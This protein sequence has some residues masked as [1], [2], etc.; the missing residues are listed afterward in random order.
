MSKYY[1]FGLKNLLLQII[2][3]ILFGI[4]LGI[5]LLFFNVYDLFAHFYWLIFLII[6]YLILHE[7]IHS[8]AY[9]INGANFKN[10][11]YGIHIEKG[12]MCCLCKENISK[13]NV[14][15]SLMAPF[16]LIGLLTYILG[17]I[18]HNSLL[19]LLSIVN[20]SGCAGDLVM[21]FNL[22]KIKDFSY[23]EFDN[24]LAFALYSSHNLEK[25]KLLG[26]KYLG[27]T[28]ELK[29]TFKKVD[30]S[31]FSLISIILYMLLGLL[32]IIFF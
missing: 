17:L 14:L 19:T 27:S 9:V 15:I 10:I 22:I 32:G 8:L 23:S 18:F 21:F 25:K 13:K 7:L 20:I 3:L 4:M 31:L 2:D 12:I 1:L 26:L 6:P 24:P 28:T 5:T 29:K 30:V 16:V 11:T